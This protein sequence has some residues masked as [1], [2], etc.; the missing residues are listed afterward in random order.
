M[1]NENANLRNNIS[2]FKVKMEDVA[3][4]YQSKMEEAQQEVEYV[5]LF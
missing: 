5:L 4:M 2:E 1:E 3:S